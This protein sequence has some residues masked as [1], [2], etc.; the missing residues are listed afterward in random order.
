[1]RTP[2]EQFVTKSPEP[3]RFGTASNNVEYVAV[4]G[5]EQFVCRYNVLTKQITV[6]DSK[7]AI[8]P[9]TLTVGRWVSAAPPLLQAHPFVL[10]HL[11]ANRQ[12]DT[13]ELLARTKEIQGNTTRI[14]IAITVPCALLRMTGL[15][16][17]GLILATNYNLSLAS[18]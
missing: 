16:R 2:W 9:M 17:I 8:E 14:T 3:F 12:M 5:N 6:D 10:V 18:V 15:S 7:G 13:Q 1:M 11:L 4:A